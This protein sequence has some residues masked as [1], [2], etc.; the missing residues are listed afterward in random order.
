MKFPFEDP[1]AFPNPLDLHGPGKLPL[2]FGCGKHVCPGKQ[3]A[4]LAVEVFL[5]ELRVL[6][7]AARLV[8]AR[9]SSRARP[10]DLLFSGA[11]LIIVTG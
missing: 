1:R 9:Q 11:D 10:S 2:T 4:Q 8:P 6:A 7:P 3:L 5:R